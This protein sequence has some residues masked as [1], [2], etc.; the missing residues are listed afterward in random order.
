VGAWAAAGKLDADA[1]GALELLDVLAMPGVGQAG[2]EVRE[3]R[4]RLYYD[5]GSPA[6]DFHPGFVRRALDGLAALAE[7]VEGQRAGEGSR[8]D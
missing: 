3:G 7:A 4:A 1:V 2:I 8:G 5:L 6:L